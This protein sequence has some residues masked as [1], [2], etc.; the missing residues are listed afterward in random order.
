[1]RFRRKRCIRHNFKDI[2]YKPRGVAM[3]GLDV[4]E[5]SH[6]ELEVM[7]LRYIEEMTQAEAAKKMGIS[8]SQYQRDLW[9]AHQKI[10]EALISGKAIHIDEDLSK[11]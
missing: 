6:E 5:V 11:Y 4:T 3:R 10:T 7:R 2:F 9:R 8:Q 1:M